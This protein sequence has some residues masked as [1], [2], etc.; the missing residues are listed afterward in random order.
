DGN[1]VLLHR[2]LGP[3]PVQTAVHAEG[4]RPSVC[5]PSAELDTTVLIPADGRAGIGHLATAFEHGVQVVDAQCRELTTPVGEVTGVRSKRLVVL[6]GSSDRAVVRALTRGEHSHCF[7]EQRAKLV[8]RSDIN[9]PSAEVG[10]VLVTRDYA[11]VKELD[12]HGAVTRGDEGAIA[13]LIV[14]CR[15]EGERPQAV[16]AVQADREPVLFH[17]LP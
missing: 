14:H 11:G 4:W 9:E 12:R 10:I 7:E 2:V 13:E 17:A 16:P 6:D 5:G 1:S 8:A 3:V 15:I